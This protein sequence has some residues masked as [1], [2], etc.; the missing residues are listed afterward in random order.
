M[1]S[2]SQVFHIKE[3]LPSALEVNPEPLTSQM[4]P[5]IGCNQDLFEFFDHTLRI[6]LAISECRHQDTKLS[7]HIG[8][9]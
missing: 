3:L 5:E 9:V 1:I 7:W 6:P 2:V 8:L 4:N